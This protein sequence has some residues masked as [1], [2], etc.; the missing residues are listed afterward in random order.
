M[1]SDSPIKML[2]HIHKTT[3]VRLSRL[4]N[5]SWQIVKATN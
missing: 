3:C 1:T 2:E 5:N 4:N